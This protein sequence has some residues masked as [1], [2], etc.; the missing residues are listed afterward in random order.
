MNRVLRVALYEYRRNVFKKSF[1]FSLLSIPWM[2]AFSVG[3]GLVLTSLENNDLPVGYIDQADVFENAIQ[4]PVSDQAEPVDFI[5]FQ[6]EDVARASLE[7]QEI[8]AYYII[9]ADFRETRQIEIVY[10]KKPG[11]NANIQWYD[12]LQIN[13]LSDQ[14]TEIAYR[15][16]AGTDVTVRSLD[17]KRTMAD[18]GPTFGNFMPLFMSMAILALILMSSGF[19][20]GAVVEEKENRT[21][22]VVVTSISPM[23]LIGGKLLGIIAIGLTLLVTWSLIVVLG[24]FAARLMGIGWFQDLGMDWSVVLATAAIAAPSYV[25]VAALMIAIGTMVTTAQEGQSFSSIFIIFHMIP[26][27]VGVAFLNKPDSSL[28]VTLSLLPFT[29]LMTIA[30]RNLFYS[31][32]TWQIALSVCVQTVSALGAIWLASR[33]FRL[34]ML[35]YGQRL[36]WRRLFQ[37]RQGGE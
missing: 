37:T 27:Y 7:A 1:L 33:A 29:S 30:M 31:V 20:M 16:A 26:L 32:P 15:T 28:A 19:L 8:Q 25:L 34:G 21:M 11:E 10:A 6:S 14:P 5:P 17:G 36:G 4:A 23:Q 3:L 12:F 22:E 35:R 9:P 13:L 2:V 24:I 18:S